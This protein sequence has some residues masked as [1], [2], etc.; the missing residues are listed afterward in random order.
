MKKDAADWVLIVLRIAGFI[1]VGVV[2]VLVVKHLQTR[3]NEA[4]ALIAGLMLVDVMTG[5]GS[6]R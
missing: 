4:L 5:R 2:L 6:K 1:C 3:P